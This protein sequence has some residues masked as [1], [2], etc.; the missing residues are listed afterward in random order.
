MKENENETAEHRAEKEVIARAQAVEIAEKKALE[1]I[2]RAEEA[3]DTF[4]EVAAALIE[5]TRKLNEIR[6][7]Q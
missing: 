6:R 5:A 2:Q 3:R 1:A 4:N 7:A